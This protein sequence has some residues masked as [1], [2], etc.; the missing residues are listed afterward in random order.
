[1]VTPGTVV[2]TCGAAVVVGWQ[3]DGGLPTDGMV[4]VTFRAVV[5]GPPTPNETVLPTG[6]IVVTVLAGAVVMAA[7]F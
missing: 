5:V 7:F 1:M 4:V 6:A 2:V 3:V